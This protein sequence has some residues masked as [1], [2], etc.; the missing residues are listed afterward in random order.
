MTSWIATVLL[1]FLWQGLI[2]GAL[3]ALALT[4]SRDA[5]ARYALGVAGLLA[6]ATAP[7]L[8]GTWL[9]FTGA[10]ALPSVVASTSQPY[11]A[12]AVVTLWLSGMS[13]LSVRSIVQAA[14]LFRLRATSMEAPPELQARF[15]A[16]RR[17]LF[18]RRYV[19]LGLVSS[20]WS[21]MASGVLRPMVLLPVSA[22]KS[23]DADQL[24]AIIAHELA[25][26]RRHDPLVNLLQIVVETALFYHP[27]VWWLSAVVREER[28]RCCDDEAVAAVGCRFTYVR[29]LTELEAARSLHAAPASNGGDLRAR[30]ERVLGVTRPPSTRERRTPYI[31]VGAAMLAS[32]VAIAATEHPTI[33]VDSTT[34]SQAEVTMHDSTVHLHL[35]DHDLYVPAPDHG[36]ATIEIHTKDAGGSDVTHTVQIAPPVPPA[37]PAKVAKPRAP[38]RPVAPKPPTKPTP[39]AAA[40]MPMAGTVTWQVQIDITNPANLPPPST[41]QRRGYRP[42]LDYQRDMTEMLRELEAFHR[43]MATFQQQ[44]ESTR[45]ARDPLR[46]RNKHF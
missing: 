8:T 6:M 30:I 10:E 3:V 44:M 41:L 24:D 45:R 5:R 36:P 7:V 29:A 39:P 15:D 20:Q 34:A 1:H 46:K 28:E 40:P 14:V 43:E 42:Q 22:L 12:Q 37:P 11:L 2:I 38:A 26:I 25:H 9:L 27:L 17:R 4:M 32:A 21:A 18:V 13:V 16:L 23:L 19:S 31:V 33:R 35:G